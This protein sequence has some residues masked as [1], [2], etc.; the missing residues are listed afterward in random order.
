MHLGSPGLQY[1]SLQI[2]LNA[3]NYRHCVEHCLADALNDRQ[4]CFLGIEMQ[5]TALRFDYGREDGSAYIAKRF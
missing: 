1:T 2:A 4:H 3:L 5:D